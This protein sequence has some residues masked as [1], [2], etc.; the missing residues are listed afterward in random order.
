MAPGLAMSAKVRVSPGW[1]SQKSAFPP[2]VSYED[3]RPRRASL[4]NGS[5]ESDDLP[6]IAGSAFE[7]GAVVQL[8]DSH[9]AGWGRLHAQLA[10]HALI[11][12]LLD[13]RR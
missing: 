9:T 3:A 7:H 13:N 10:E 12:V 11:E 2:D 4:R 6:I 1:S 8:D 5:D